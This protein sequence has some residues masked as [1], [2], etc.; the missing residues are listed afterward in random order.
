MISPSTREVR[1]L[2]KI[3]TLNLAFSKDSK[4]VYGIRGDDDRQYL[5][6]M[7][8]ATLSTKNIRELRREDWPQ[9]TMFPGHRLSMAP[10]GKT[11][12]YAAGIFK[13]NLWMLR[14]FNPPGMLQR[15]GFAR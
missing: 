7:D 3:D 9:T 15:L 12:T 4:R 2:G 1:S 6:Y 5:F 11:A 10:D 8:L 14:G 13:S